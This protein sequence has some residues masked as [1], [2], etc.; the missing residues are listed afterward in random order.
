MSGLVQ[1]GD[2]RPPRPP[3]RRPEWLRIKVKDT[4]TY[5]DEDSYA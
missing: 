1:L 5:R 2:A 4:Q 3:G